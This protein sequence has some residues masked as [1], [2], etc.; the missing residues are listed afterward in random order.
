[1]SG[2]RYLLDTNVLSETRRRV[3][4]PGLKA[5]LESAESTALYLSVLT[6]GELRKGVLLKTASDRE[7]GVRLASWVDGLEQSFSDR[8][9]GIDAPTARTW[10]ELSAER[11]RPVID[12]LFAATA[13]I[14]EMTLVTRNEK[15]VAG[16]PGLKVLNP[17][18]NG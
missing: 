8:I 9:I 6:L 12:T 4:H 14:H 11:P 2:L 1:V 18:K 17:W 16:I 10:G 5:F 3:P 7:T 13:L 15:D